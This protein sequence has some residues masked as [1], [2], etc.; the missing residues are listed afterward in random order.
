MKLAIAIFCALAALA[1]AARADEIQFTN[2]DKLTGKIVKLADGK[3]GFDSKVAGTLSLNW[4]DVATLASDD[5]VTLQLAGGSVVVD[6]LVPSAPGTVQ[7]A[8][9]DK[10][11]AQTIQLASAEK[12]NPEPVHW[13]GTLVAGA[14]IERGNTVKTAA[15]VDLNAVRRSEDDRITF[16]AGYAGEQAAPSGSNDEST[17]KRR[18]YGSLQYD[19]FF[20]K[21]LYGWANTAAEKDG[22][23]DLDLRFTAGAGAGYQFFETD[24]LKYNIEGGLAWF[25][26]NY[27]NDTPHRDYVALRLASNLDWTL[28]PGLTF[29]QYTKLFPSLESSKDQL[30]DTATGLRY[31]IWGNFFGESKV[32]WVWDST[33]ADGKK[34]QDL[35]FLLGIGYGFP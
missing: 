20:G 28:Y 9:N 14:D 19:L 24:T 16:K 10:L 5:P 25:S 32:L 3:L 22:V 21:Q 30:V 1:F 4:T 26:E 6:K 23:A 18:M 13:A 27:S 29:F 31:K 2:G 35:A 15:N 11:S 8:G 12:L 17:T 33:P 7:T 34:R